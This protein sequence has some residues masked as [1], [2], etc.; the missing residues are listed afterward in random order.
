MFFFSMEEYILGHMMVTKVTRVS[1]M[2][3]GEVYE[4]CNVK[5]RVL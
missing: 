3:R 4:A 2:L 5:N 1:V